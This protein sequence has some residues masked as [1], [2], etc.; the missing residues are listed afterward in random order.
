MRSATACANSGRAAR[1]TRTAASVFMLR[2]ERG[3]RNVSGPPGAGG[4]ERKSLT[5]FFF[6]SALDQQRLDDR[7]AAAEGAVQRR[8]VHRAAARE[9]HVAEALPVRA[10]HPAV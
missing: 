8:L 4:P 3:A 10:R 1:E 2:S 6:Q 9:D 7:I 5:R